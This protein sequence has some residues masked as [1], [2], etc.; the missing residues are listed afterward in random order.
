[1]QIQV[2]ERQEGFFV[3]VFLVTSFL[4]HAGFIMILDPYPPP[5][6]KGHKNHK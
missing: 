2:F 1:M 5:P 4:M 6:K 3:C